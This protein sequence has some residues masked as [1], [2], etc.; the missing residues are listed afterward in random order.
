MKSCKKCLNSLWGKFAQSTDAA[1]YEY[2]SSYHELVKKVMCDSVIVN[3]WHIINEN[4]IEMRYH[5]SETS[6]V[7]EK[8][9]SISVR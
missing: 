5:N 1:N 2:H 9:R 8:Y 4:C 3:D 6:K 7:G